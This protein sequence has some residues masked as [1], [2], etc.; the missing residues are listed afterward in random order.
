MSTP[1]VSGIAAMLKQKNMNVT[2]S[3]LK[4]MVIASSNKTSLYNDNSGDFDPNNKY[5]AG[6][7]DALKAVNGTFVKTINMTGGQSISYKINVTNSSTGLFVAAS[8][9]ENTS[10]THYIITL[11]LTDPNTTVID[12]SVNPNNT[13]QQVGKFS[14]A[15]GIWAIT[16]K[17]VNNTNKTVSIASTYNLYSA[18]EVYLLSPANNTT[19]QTRTWN[20]TYKVNETIS[21]ISYCQLY[22]NFTG[23]WAANISNSTPVVNYAVN[24]ITFNN[25]TLTNLSNGVYIWN[26][27]CNNTGGVIGFGSKN[28]TIGIDA[29][30]PVITINTPINNYNTS[31]NITLNWSISDVSSITLNY[32]INKTTNV[33]LGSNKT[34]AVNISVAAGFNQNITVYA[35]DL[36][37][38]RSSATVIFNIDR[39]APN[40]TVLYPQNGTQI[41]TT[42]IDINYTASDNLQLSKVWY[43]LE[44]GTA[45]DITSGNSSTILNFPGE[46]G[47]DVYANDSV[48]NV[49]HTYVT[50]LVTFDMNMT[51]WSKN[52]RASAP[53][54]KG[55]N[56]TLNGL[57]VTNNDSTTVN[58]T[59]KIYV[60]TTN[61]NITFTDFSGLN[62]NWVN[63]FNVTETSSNVTNTISNIGSNASKLIYIS[64]ANEFLSDNEYSGAITFFGTASNYSDFFYCEPDTIFNSSHCAKISACASFTGTACYNDSLTTTTVYVPHFSAVV[65]AVDTKAPSITVNSPT[66]TTYGNPSLAYSLKANLTTSADTIYCNMSLMANGSLTKPSDSKTNYTNTNGSSSYLWTIGPLHNGVYN[67]TISCND[68]HGNTNTTTKYFTVNDAIKPEYS[69]IDMYTIGMDYGTAQWTSNEPVNR[70]IKYGTVDHSL[71]N[72]LTNASFGTFERVKIDGL[73]D[74]DQYFFN[75]TG[76]DYA[77]NCN[78]TGPYNFTTDENTTT[79]SNE[80]GEGAG[81]GGSGNQTNTTTTIKSWAT[82]DAYEK[83][84]MTISSSSIPLSKIS[85]IL[86]TNTQNSELTVKSLG[87]TLPS[88]LTNLPAPV[89][90]YF[91]ITASLSIRNSMTLATVV[92][93]IPKSYISNNNYNYSTITLYNNDGTNWE[94][95][96]TVLIDTTGD[97]YSYEAN[98][99][100]FS[101]FAI[102][103]A[104]NIETYTPPNQTLNQTQ[105]QTTITNTTN[106]TSGIGIGYEQPP[107][108][109]MPI[110]IIIIV[111]AVAAILIFLY[112][113]GIIFSRSDYYTQTKRPIIPQ[114]Q[115]YKPKNIKKIQQEQGL[116]DGLKKGPQK[117]DDGPE[118]FRLK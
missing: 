3:E 113:K 85:F 13:I 39:T 22:G 30:S 100:H 10:S 5:G 40:L 7:V 12:T 107:D 38:N 25:L 57:D 50:F 83:N 89:Y 111:A 52:L 58:G 108:Y 46:Y 59:T 105:N 45:V 81:S 67:I 29:S 71:P 23:A 55:L 31:G 72:N 18:P 33:T 19:T 90:K 43:K 51:N 79:P 87:N 103:M 21:N 96:N 62:A 9:N 48:D 110:I 20:F 11:N 60:N 95:L 2:A 24:N 109:T 44:N 16:I 56:I 112:K 86:N 17:N 61:F 66:N 88:G 28:F 80:G 74:N 92:V 34:G 70:T 94:K 14:P 82:I 99:T 41:N 77:G 65:A 27:Y 63:R 35:K 42:S 84:T 98:T 37:N 15:Q 73:N 91:S 68:T 115:V 49:N 117:Q 75:I 26:V 106:Q 1:H 97:Y 118:L 4:A 104:P 8:W 69:D 93:K 78:E 53:D 64:N 102:T 6:R 36:F 114:K 101:T 76:C 116:F 47:L 32:T 54:V